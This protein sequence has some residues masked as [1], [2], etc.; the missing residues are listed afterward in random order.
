MVLRTLAG[1]ALLSLTVPMAGCRE[2]GQVAGPPLEQPFVSATLECD[3]QMRSTGEPDY[4][5][6]AEPDTEEPVTQANRFVDG[7]HLRRGYLDLEI[8]MAE[9]KPSSQTIALVSDGRS[10]GILKYE[11]DAQLGWHLTSTE[12][13]SPAE[14]KT[15]TTSRLAQ[16][17]KC[18]DR[19][20][21]SSPS[22]AEVRK[23]SI[24][25]VLVC[26]WRDFPRSAKPPQLI[27]EAWLPPKERATLQTQLGGAFGGITD[28]GTPEDALPHVAYT[29]YLDDTESGMWRIDVPDDFCQGFQMGGEPYVSGWVSRTLRTAGAGSRTP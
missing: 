24:E 15:P 3:N 14:V 21:Y 23:L 28:C 22:R 13:C 20:W 9:Q 16:G 27:W 5:I 29:L 2:G 11:N 8:A 1:L 26:A 6:P 10:V 17:V 25:A 19:P 18:A 4:A 7:T 12:V